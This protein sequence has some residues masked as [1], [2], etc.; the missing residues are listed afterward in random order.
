[1]N[2]RISELDI[3]F[4]FEDFQNLSL[5]VGKIRFSPNPILYD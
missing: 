4:L 5:R 1:M 2:F 3:N